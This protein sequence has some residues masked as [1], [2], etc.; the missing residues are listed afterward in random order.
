MTT[1]YVMMDGA[2]TNRSMIKMFLGSESPSPAAGISSV[3]S[4]NIFDVT[5]PVV[6]N[7]D[8]KHV[9]KK[10]RNG[11]ESSKLKNSSKNDS[12]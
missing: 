5:E 11:L 12:S 3:S 6:L 8:N 4:K 1:D 7:Q 9:F 10:I 2:W